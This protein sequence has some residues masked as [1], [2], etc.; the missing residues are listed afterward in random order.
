MICCLLSATVLSPDPWIREVHPFQSQWA[1]ASSLIRFSSNMMLLRWPWKLHKTKCLITVYGYIFNLK[2]WLLLP[3]IL[4][5]W[6]ISCHT[7]KQG[8]HSHQLLQPQSRMTWWTLKTLRRKEYLPCSS[9]QAAATPSCEPWR[10]ERPGL[11]NRILAPDTFD[12]KG[13]YF[14]KPSLLHL[15]HI[16]KC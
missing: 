4:R 8:C 9:H 5:K 11:E 12:I 15:P 14:S 2:W 7:S 10:K 16:G 1:L 6:I 3:S 13:T